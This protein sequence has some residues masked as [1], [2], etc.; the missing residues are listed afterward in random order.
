MK[1]LRLLTVAAFILITSK[2][3]TENSRDDFSSDDNEEISGATS[4]NSFNQMKARIGTLFAD[5]KK[6]QAEHALLLQEKENLDTQIKSSEEQLQSLGI[7]LERF[8]TKRRQ[9]KVDVPPKDDLG[10]L[11]NEL[12]LRESKV[13]YLKRQSLE[14]DDQIKSAQSQMDGL[15]K[16]Q[17][18]LDEKSKQIQDKASRVL[19]DQSKDIEDLKAKQK[20]LEYQGKF[21]EEK[22]TELQ[23]QG[24]EYSEKMR[25]FSEANKGLQLEAMQLKSDIEIKKKEM[26][27]LRDKHTL[28]LRTS[29]L[30]L[31]PKEEEKAE[32]S[33]QISALESEYKNLDK[34]VNTTLN[35]QN[36]K[37]QLLEK[38]INLD[39]ENQ[40][41]REKI[42][43]L[44]KDQA[45][46]SQ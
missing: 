37:K 10:S 43:T 42:S 9:M 24:S 33:D 27:L 19:E 38:I 40:G 25:T 41:L 8:Q 14:F 32:L 36:D 4:F 22:M 5:N 34:A 26:D 13:A 12:L 46:V 29:Q 15:N 39:Q 16:E 28:A 18:A 20:S 7:N 3:Y 30:D 21:N 17:I 23:K 31:R 6:L 11:Q 2:G 44:Q 1:I 35:W 45:E